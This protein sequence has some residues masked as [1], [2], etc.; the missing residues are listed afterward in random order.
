MSTYNPLCRQFHQLHERGRKNKRWDPSSW[1]RERG[2]GAETAIDVAPIVISSDEED[3]DRLLHLND[4]ALRLP[5]RL[6][7]ATTTLMRNP[8][9]SHGSGRGHPCRLNSTVKRRRFA[10]RQTPA[11]TDGN[12]QAQTDTDGHKQRCCCHFPFFILVVMDVNMCLCCICLSD[13]EFSLSAP[14]VNVRP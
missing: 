10:K 9:I 7:A 8:C 4:A 1:K 12:R 2:C 14:S 5:E 6:L 11:D 3:G 13:F